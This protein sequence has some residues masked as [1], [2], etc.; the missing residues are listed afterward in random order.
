MQIILSSLVFKTKLSI[1]NILGLF[2]TILGTFYYSYMKLSKVDEK[3]SP[4]LIES[5]DENEDELSLSTSSD[6]ENHQKLIQT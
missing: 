4:I 5:D 1:L 3:L 2:I 6:S